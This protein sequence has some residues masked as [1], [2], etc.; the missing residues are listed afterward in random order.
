MIRDKIIMDA[1][2]VLNRWGIGPSEKNLIL[3][4]SSYEATHET[5]LHYMKCE[6]IIAIDDTLKRL[7][8]NP[9][10][11]DGFMTMKNYNQPF[12]GARPIDLLLSGDIKE[13]EKA[14]EAINAVSRMSF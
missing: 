12:C 10:N 4:L 13:I 11:V 14:W 3:G 9:K 8:E 6:Y 7:F 1:E 2:K 5:Q